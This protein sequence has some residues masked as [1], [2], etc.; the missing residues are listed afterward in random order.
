[1]YLEGD[2]HIQKKQMWSGCPR[3]LCQS[4]GLPIWE[5]YVQLGVISQQQIDLGSPSPSAWR[6]ASIPG[7]EL[8]EPSYFLE[9]LR[10]LWAVVTEFPGAGGLRS[11]PL[12]VFVYSVA[13]PKGWPPLSC[14][15]DPW[16]L[17]GGRVTVSPFQLGAP[18]GSGHS[19]KGSRAPNPPHS[20]PC[21]L[22]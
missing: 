8:S 7:E 3:L 4:E 10:T 11:S 1:M 20:C 16:I 6:K 2:E 15:P 17:D 12:L 5:S 19:A 13:F 22:S 14:F 18:L 9:E 21:L